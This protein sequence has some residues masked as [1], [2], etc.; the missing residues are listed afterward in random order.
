MHLCI[1]TK[2]V[3]NSADSDFK[4]D[5]TYR[6]LLNFNFEYTNVSFQLSSFISAFN[7]QPSFQLQLSILIFQLTTFSSAFNF[8]LSSFSFLFQLSLQLSA[9]SFQLSAFSFHRSPTP[10]PWSSW[11]PRFRGI[12]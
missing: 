12:L 6:V 9:F 5:D 10:A 3:F 11:P 4:V 7:F 2:T 1:D 8:Q